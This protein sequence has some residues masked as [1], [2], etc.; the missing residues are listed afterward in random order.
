MSKGCRI[1]HPTLQKGTTMKVYPGPNHTTI[2]GRHFKIARARANAARLTKQSGRPFEV[3]I[4]DF[5]FWIMTREDAEKVKPY[6]R[7]APAPAGV[8]GPYQPV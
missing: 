5:T 8:Y 1:P 3:V 7:I 2:H 6:Y 4:G